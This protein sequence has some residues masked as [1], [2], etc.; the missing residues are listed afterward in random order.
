MEPR[1]GARERIEPEFLSW[2]RP[3][4]H[5]E[6]STGEVKIEM[7]RDFRPKDRSQKS[8]ARSK[9]ADSKYQPAGPA[10]SAQG[11]SSFPRPSAS[12]FESK[13][14]EAGDGDDD[15]DDDDGDEEELKEAIAALG[16]DDADFAL[17]SS[18]AL[19]GKG[20]V[21]ADNEDDAGSVSS[22]RAGCASGRILQLTNFAIISLTSAW[23]WR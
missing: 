9:N 21:S 1:L 23:T 3:Y 19:K 12:K 6:T 15:D 7:A 13:R 4:Q 2:T 14:Q 11:Q 16:G 18:Q 22:S 17:V 8:N 20:K 10:R 5:Q